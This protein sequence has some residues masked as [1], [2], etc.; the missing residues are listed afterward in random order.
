MYDFGQSLGLVRGKGVHGVH[1]DA[2]D[3][4]ALMLL[5]EIVENGVQKDSVF[6]DPFLW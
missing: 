2:L 6:P 4:W 3:A 5:Q 1:D